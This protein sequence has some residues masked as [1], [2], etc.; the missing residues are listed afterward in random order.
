MIVL[1]ATMLMQQTTGWSFLAHV[2]F[3]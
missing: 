3:G 1:F 2:V